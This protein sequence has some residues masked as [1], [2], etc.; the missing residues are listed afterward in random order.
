MPR[1]TMTL[2]DVTYKTAEA[3]AVKHGD[4]ISTVLNQFIQLGMEY[5]TQNRA[6]RQAEKYCHQLT[7]Q[8]NALMKS[9][10]AHFLKMTPE[11]FEKLKLASVERYQELLQES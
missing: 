3:L 5:A 10:T 11:D 2:S 4:S 1:F 9:M 6:Q 8:T 7:I